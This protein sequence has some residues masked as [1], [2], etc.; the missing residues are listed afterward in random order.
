[1]SA[2]FVNKRR[3]RKEVREPKVR[4]IEFNV[5][6][7]TGI[8]LAAGAS[9]RMGSPKALLDYRGETFAARL[10][11]V[12][13]EFCDPVIVVLGYHAEI[14][15]P[16]IEALTRANANLRIAINSA[17][18]RGQLSSLQEGLRAIPAAAQGFMFA[19]VDSPA[20]SVETVRS[21]VAAFHARDAQTQLVV[22]CFEANH[23]HPVLAARSI[24][25]ELLAL[26]SSE[27]A[28][29]VICAHV[30]KT[31]YLVVDDS[32]ILVDVDDPEAYQ[33]LLERS[34][35]TSHQKSF[36]TSDLT[37]RETSSQA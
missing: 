9:T 37:S 2:G 29:A 32:G 5:T 8:I 28:R 24:G 14:L 26:P 19:P 10:V 11:R 20:V 3:E 35:Q 31:Q 12:F 1:V 4:N 6:S 23:G 18:E 34:C 27:N 15:R 25:H 30:A 21:I 22:P 13:S 17:P 36:Q 33:K 16:R 7:I